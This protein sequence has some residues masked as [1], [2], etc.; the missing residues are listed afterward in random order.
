MEIHQ[1]DNAVRQRSR[2]AESASAAPAPS[3]STPSSS[4]STTNQSHLN[5]RINPSSRRRRWG[6][7]SY[8]L[9]MLLGVPFWWLTTSVERRSLS[10]EE[11][12][13]LDVVG[14]GYI[15]METSPQSLILRLV[16]TGVAIQ[17]SNPHPR[18]IIRLSIPST[19]RALLRDARLLSLQLA[20]GT[21]RVR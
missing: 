21:Q 3:P 10:I 5:S 9:Y 2:P 7:F 20:G 18:Y 6:V 15:A 13:G 1:S 8:P 14:V 16:N 11:V 12:E 4:T 17:I 19:T